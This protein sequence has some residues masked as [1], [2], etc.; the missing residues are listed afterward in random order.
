MFYREDDREGQLRAW[1]LADELGAKGWAVGKNLTIDFRW[2]TG[3]DAWI[4]STVMDLLV[5][6]PSVVVANSD[7]VARAVQL[8]SK[9]VPVVFIGSGDPVAQGLVQSFA[10]PG[11]SLTGFTVLE[12]SIGPKWLQLLKEIAPQTQRVSVLLNSANAGSK[13]LLRS[14]IEEVS[15]FGFE[16]IA[17]E[18]GEPA[19][20]EPAFS[21]NGDAVDS[22]SPE[23]R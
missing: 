5:F 21:K 12:P 7:P 2:G 16:V 4:S 9:T 6:S 15:K 11:G 10:H 18:I 20:I 23:A 17:A 22:L 14:C 1:A 8:A 19:D 3:D 13:L